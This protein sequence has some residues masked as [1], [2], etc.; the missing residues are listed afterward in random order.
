MGGRGSG[1]IATKTLTDHCRSID[2]AALMRVGRTSGGLS[3]S[4][5]GRVVSSIRWAL[6]ADALEVSVVTDGTGVGLGPRRQVI[7]LMA[8]SAGFGG[9]RQWLQCSCG[10]RCR[11]IYLL[12]AG[13]R[14][15][16]CG[17]LSYRSQR[18]RPEERALRMAE[19]MSARLGGVAYDHFP[20]KPARMHRS[21]YERLQLRHESLVG[22]V[23][24][25][26]GIA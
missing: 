19:A 9:S 5:S 17:S 21:T 24:A 2:L 1:R 11:V 10:R 8:T 12:A 16:G 7:P 4:M 22:R 15:R 3:W 23:E 6:K 26:D 25:A 14:C 13:T 20:D 18:Q